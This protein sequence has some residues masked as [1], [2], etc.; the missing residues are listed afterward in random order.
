MCLHTAGAL[1]PQWDS[2]NRGGRIGRGT[3]FRERASASELGAKQ[4]KNLNLL[5]QQVFHV[6]VFTETAVISLS[7]DGR[8]PPPPHRVIFQP[9]LLTAT[10]GLVLQMN[11]NLIFVR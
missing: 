5:T 2:N 8:T 3:F 11:P 10:V 4:P 6:V 1:C 7:A 9:R